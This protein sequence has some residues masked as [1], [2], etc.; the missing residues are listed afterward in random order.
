M[1]RSKGGD[2]KATVQLSREAIIAKEMSKDGKVV[3]VSD[4]RLLKPITK[5]MIISL[6]Y[7]MRFVEN[8]FSCNGI[9]RSTGTKSKRK[10]TALNMLLESGKRV[11]IAEFRSIVGQNGLPVASA[12]T[13]LLYCYAPL[14]S[15]R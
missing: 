7:G 2:V 14:V 3:T 5:E 11:S 13:N 8:D 6:V 4:L 12:L 1:L 9:Y 10:P 15:Y